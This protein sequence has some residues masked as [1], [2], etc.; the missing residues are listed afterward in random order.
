M[1]TET[2]PVRYE[3]LTSMVINLKKLL[4]AQDKDA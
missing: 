1:D 2:N 3:N 4:R